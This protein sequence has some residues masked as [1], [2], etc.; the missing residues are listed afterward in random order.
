VIVTQYK[1]FVH[2]VLKRVEISN[3][4]DGESVLIYLPNGDVVSIEQE[5]TYTKVYTDSTEVDHDFSDWTW[6]IPMEVE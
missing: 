3:L 2:T 5:D 6:H 1:K 4:K